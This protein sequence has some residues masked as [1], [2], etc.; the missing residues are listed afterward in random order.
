MFD[1]PEPTTQEL[2]S[3]DTSATVDVHGDHQ[4]VTHVTVDSI[5]PSRTR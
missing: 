4:N 5:A 2:V 1:E 3:Q